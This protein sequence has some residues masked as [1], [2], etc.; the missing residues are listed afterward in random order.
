VICTTVE[1]RQDFRIPTFFVS[2]T[3][4]RE[5]RLGNLR[6]II[7]TSLRIFHCNENNNITDDVDGKFV[8]D[9]KTA[10]HHHRQQEPRTVKYGAGSGDLLEGLLRLLLLPAFFLLQNR[11]SHAFS[12]IRLARYLA[13]PYRQLFREQLH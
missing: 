6:N 4:L 3:E 10:R 2:G 5:I 13:I 11:L 1:T 12:P 9:L 7:R 8:A